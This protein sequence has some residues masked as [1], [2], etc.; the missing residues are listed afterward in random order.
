MTTDKLKR[1]EEKQKITC[2]LCDWRGEDDGVELCQCWFYKMG[3]ELHQWGEPV[4][5]QKCGQFW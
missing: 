5:V 3:Q 1:Y 4:Y 2:S